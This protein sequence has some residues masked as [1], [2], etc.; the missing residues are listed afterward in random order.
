MEH[1]SIA[2]ALKRHYEHIQQRHYDEIP[3]VYTLW[4]ERD[5]LVT[6]DIAVVHG[7]WRCYATFKQLGAM[8]FYATSGEIHSTWD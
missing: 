5:G 8:G 4:N 1:S 6:L 2:R 3:E 7:C